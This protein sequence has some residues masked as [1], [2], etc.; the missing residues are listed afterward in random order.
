V[1]LDQVDRELSRTPNEAERNALVE[2]W[3]LCKE[4]YCLTRF[5]TTTKS[6]KASKLTQES[7]INLKNGAY[8]VTDDHIKKIEEYVAFGTKSQGKVDLDVLA[9]VAIA[10]VH[11]FVSVD[12]SLLGNKRIKDF[13]KQKDH[14]EIYYPS[15][16]LVLF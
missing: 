14:I 10:G 12:D 11:F 2:T 1:G 13:V 8:F 7:G 5:E 4:K 3:N 6:K 16:F 9:T 15:E